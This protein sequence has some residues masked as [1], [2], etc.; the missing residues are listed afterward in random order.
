MAQIEN[1]YI[2]HGDKSLEYE[3]NK[4]IARGGSNVQKYGERMRDDSLLLQ[5]P[6]RAGRKENDGGGPRGTS[7]AIFG[8]DCAPDK[9]YKEN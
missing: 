9:G 1:D 5:K 2:E 6:T 4:I 3:Y 8:V 7:R